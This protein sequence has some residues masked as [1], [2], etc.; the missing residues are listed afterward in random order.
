MEAKLELSL[1]WA[2]ENPADFTAQV[3]KFMSEYQGWKIL[4]DATRQH[5]V[6]FIAQ[7][8]ING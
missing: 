3:K 5:Y 1:N 2:D 7:R 4:I 6:T 8:I